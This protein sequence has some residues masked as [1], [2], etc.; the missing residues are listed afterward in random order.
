LHFVIQLNAGMAMESL[1]F[2]FITPTGDTMT[3]ADRSTIQG[4]LPN[5]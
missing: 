1:P 4:V 2:R 5:R 3:P